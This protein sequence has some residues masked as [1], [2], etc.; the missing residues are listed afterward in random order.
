MLFFHRKL[1]FD[2]NATTRVDKRVIKKMVRVLKKNYANPSSLYH[3]AFD[4]AQILSESRK[5]IAE[6]INASDEEIVFTGSAT[7]ANNMVLKSLVEQ[8]G[9]SKKKIISSP[10]EHPSIMQTLRYLEDK[11]G[12]LV[13]YLPVD[14]HGVV[15]PVDLE[16]LID[17]KTLLV[18][19]MLANNEIG[20]VQNIKELTAISREHDVYFLSDCVQ[21]LGKIPVDVQQLGVDYATFSA[22]KIHGPKGVG[23]L[24]VKKGCPVSSIIHGGHQENGL[25]AGTE[26]THNIAG[27]AEAAKLI[28]DQIGRYNEV[29]PLATMLVQGLKQ[30]FPAMIVNSSASDS[31]ANT[32]SLTFPGHNNGVML[33]MLNMYGISVSAGSACNTTENTP[34]HVLTAIGL[35]ADAARE[36]IRISLPD[37]TKKKDIKYALKIFDHYFHNKALSVEMISPTQVDETF[38]SNENVCMID[39]RFNYERNG[40]KSFSNSSEYPFF[41]FRKHWKTIPKNK[42]IVLVCQMGI[43]SPLIA[44]YLRSKGYKKVGF[45]ATGMYGWWLSHPELRGR[46]TGINIKRIDD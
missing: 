40:I 6:S 25:R 2:N 8:F 5:Q 1:Y 29:K 46:L 21:A 37:T 14:N 41:S 20:T 38:L 30:I 9:G 23:A 35:S 31:L 3:T 22:H 43:N 45:I 24:F 10:I 26:S 34:S 12:C 15:S 44:Y 36:T 19:C 4:C 32:I 7:E 27:F 11:C 33:G 16:S 28:E 17:S 13:E 18:V 42:H 39:V